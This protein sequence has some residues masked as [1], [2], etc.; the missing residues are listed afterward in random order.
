MGQVSIEKSLL[1]GIIGI[2]C[3]CFFMIIYYRFPGVMAVI[4]LAI[5]ALL[6]LAIFKLFSVTLTLAGVA[7]FILSIGM[8]VD[9]NVL[10]FERII[11]ELRNG[12][13]LSSAIDNGFG[14][15]WLA[16]RD[17]NLTT[18]ISALILAWLG[19]SSIRGFGVTLAIGVVLSMFTAISIT[20]T[21]LKLFKMKNTWFFGVKKI[22]NLNK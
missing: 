14:R 22:D 18:L 16:I 8:A 19:A 21:F 10:I 17:S 13:S 4:S 12:N 3:V 5:Y 15:A 20:K 9:A 7:G 6:M 1:A 11:D 2:L